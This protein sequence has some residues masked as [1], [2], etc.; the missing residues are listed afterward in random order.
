LLVGE[1]VPF[2]TGSATGASSST[3]NPFQTIERHDIGVTLKV[4]PRVNDDNSILMT[5]VQTV[6][7]ISDSAVNA[8]DIVTSKRSITTQV[9]IEDDAILVLGGLIRD[10]LSRK[11]NKIPLL[12]NLPILGRLFR[13]TS[14]QATKKNLIVFLHPRILRTA[15]DGALVTRDQYEQMQTR[16]VRSNKGRDR[17]LIPGAAPELPPWPENTDA[18]G[19]T[20]SGQAVLPESPEGVRES[21]GESERDVIERASQSEPEIAPDNESPLAP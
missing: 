5:I 8:A 20:I 11:A 16:Q 6:E 13:T 19:E 12:G 4:K 3:T 21:E 2:I 17:Y 9:I 18:S 10:D 15:A 7:A 1:N 14:N